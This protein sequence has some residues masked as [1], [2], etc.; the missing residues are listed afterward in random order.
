[1]TAKCGTAK[2]G[3]AKCGTVVP[4]VILMLH[5]GPHRD[6]NGL[7]WI[8][9]VHVVLNCRCH[10]RLRTAESTRSQSSADS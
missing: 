8:P 4:T 1:M 5:G 9:F 10:V 7:N 3:T 2:C 6:S